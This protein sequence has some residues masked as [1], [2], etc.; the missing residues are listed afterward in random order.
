[1]GKDMTFCNCFC[2]N[3]ECERN[4]VNINAPGCYSFADLSKTDVC[5]GREERE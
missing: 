4:M 2:K 5:A 1:M 3:A